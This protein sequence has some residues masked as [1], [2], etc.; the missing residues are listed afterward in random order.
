MGRLW[1]AAAMI[2]RSRYGIC[3]Q[4]KKCIPS[5]ATKAQISSKVL[6]NTAPG[7]LQSYQI[8]H[9]NVCQS[10]I[11]KRSS[12]PVRAPSRA[13]NQENH[14]TFLTPNF[15]LTKRRERLIANVKRGTKPPPMERPKLVNRSSAIIALKGTPTAKSLFGNLER[16]KAIT[17][18]KTEK[19]TS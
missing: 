17:V 12:N 5:L 18:L 4:A 9:P 7:R 19:T 2:T 10:Q 15:F 13:N 11:S 14:L 8:G 3:P 16:K 1:S 6:C